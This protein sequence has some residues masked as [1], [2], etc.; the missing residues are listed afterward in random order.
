MTLKKKEPRAEYPQFNATFSPFAE[1]LKA[2][3]G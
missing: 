3:L 1:I 2:L